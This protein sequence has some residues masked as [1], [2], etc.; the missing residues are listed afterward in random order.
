MVS[1]FSALQDL[2]DVMALAVRP[3]G[4]YLWYNDAFA[5]FASG[6]AGGQRPDHIFQV[7]PRLLAE[8]R[9]AALEPALSTG[10][11][12]E[13]MQY[14]AGSRRWTYARALDPACGLGRAVVVTLAPCLRPM[15]RTV[16]L[17]LLDHADLDEMRKLSFRELIV[18][19][20]IAEG[21]SATECAKVEHRST[22]TVEN[23]LAS[24]YSKLKIPNRARLIQFACE[25]GI[26]GFTRDEWRRIIDASRDPRL[27]EHAVKE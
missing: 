6:A 15:E 16:G 25:R 20:L 2:P 3:N 13:Y 5:E 4:E 18:L 17:P 27:G 21:L 14:L 10:N 12:V 7:M 9:L 22:K 11:P 26:L 1:T 8:E 24:V 19:R 23:Q